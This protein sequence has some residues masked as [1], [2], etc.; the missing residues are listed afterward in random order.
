MRF[1][2]SSSIR[3]ARHCGP[4]STCG[5]RVA[6]PAHGWTSAASTCWPPSASSALTALR[7]G[8]CCPTLAMPGSGAPPRTAVCAWPPGAALSEPW[9]RGLPCA[10]RKTGPTRLRLSVS[11]LLARLETSPT[12][13]SVTP[14]TRAQTSLHVVRSWDTEQ[15]ALVRTTRLLFPLSGCWE[16]QRYFTLGNFVSA[17]IPFASHWPF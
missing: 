2:C 13:S 16:T 11:P 3:T 9:D 8:Y 15:E 5:P 6:A 10:A 7:T 14:V 4:S 1:G 12:H 17:F